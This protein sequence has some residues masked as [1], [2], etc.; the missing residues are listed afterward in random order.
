MKK[1]I[2]AVLLSLA[3]ILVTAGIAEA[4]LATRQISAVYQNMK[5]YVNGM[6]V[7]VPPD[8]E[9]FIYN[10]RTFVPI[11]VVAEA[12]NQQVE[13]VDAAKAV[14]ISGTVQTD[15]NLLAQKDKEIQDLKAQLAQ[16]NSEITSLNNTITSLQNNDNDTDDEVIND[17]EDDLLSDYD[18]LEDVDIDDI[19]LD[20]D[21]D[22]VDV[23]I[24]VDLGDYDSEWEDLTDSD[25]ENWIEDIVNDIQDELSGDTNVDG[26][27]IDTDSDDTLVD[28]SKDGDD[29]L[30][31]EFEDDDYRDGGSDSD[32]VVDNLEGEDYDVSGIAFTLDEVDYDDNYRVDVYLYA[33]DD[34]ASSEWDDLSSTTID[35]EVIDICKEIA[36]AF[37]DDADITLLT[38][39]AYFY[40]EDD[41]LLDSAFDYDVSDEDLS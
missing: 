23:D 39:T 28:F 29:S 41:D 37:E 4:A 15:P 24:E 6:A 32:D 35:N 40:D 7:S 25:I 13:W 30:D 12:L 27:I 17:L 11:R 16:K 3:I 14:K 1:R 34:D 33:D 21:E 38:V 5:I 10:G 2:I 26:T 31:V 8:E 36:D 20:G 9:P 22:D 19:S 18:R